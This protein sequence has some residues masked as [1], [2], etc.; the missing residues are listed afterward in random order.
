MEFDAVEALFDEYYEDDFSYGK[1]PGDPNAYTVGRIMNHNVVL[2]FMP[3]MGKA[4]SAS[5]AASFRTSF[6]GIRIG[7]VVGI[8]GGVPSA[9]HD[10]QLTV[11]ELMATKAKWLKLDDLNQLRHSQALLGWCPNAT[12]TLGTNLIDTKAVG[13]SDAAPKKTTWYGSLEIA[14]LDL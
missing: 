9:K 10:R 5:L 4:N 1:A 13:W 8:C 3:G 14:R 2:A 6:T 7:I 11:A 12:V